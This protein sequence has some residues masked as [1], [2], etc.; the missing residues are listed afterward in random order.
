MVS[1]KPP[2][3]NEIWRL[4]LTRRKQSI[5]YNIN[6]GEI[7]MKTLD[8][9]LYYCEEPE[10]V[11]AVLLTG[12]WGCG[13][14][15][16]IDNELKEALENKAHL[17]RIS[18]FGITTIEG[19]HMAVKQEWISEYTKGKKWKGVVE[20]AQQGREIAGKLDFL[21]E[22]VRGI[23]TTDWQSF[24]EIE[25]VIEEKPV[26]L[27]FDDLERSCLDTVDVLGTINNYCENQKFH[28]IIVA[29]QDKMKISAESTAIPIEFEID[30]FENEDD[31]DPAKRAVGKIK[32]KAPKDA[33]ELSY[34][35]IKEKIIHRTIRYI[36][37]YAGIV[38]TVIDKTKY[39]DDKYK[40]FVKECE[41][42]IW[43]LFAPDRNTYNESQNSKRPHN[44]R[45]LKCAIRDFY[46]VYEILVENGFE[47]IDKWFYSFISY[48]IAYKANIAKEGRYGTLLSDK[49]VQEL[50]PAFQNQYM[51][52]TVK[53]WI[54]RGMWDVDALTYEIGVVQSKKKAE[55]PSDIVRTHRI[56]DVEE[57]VIIEGFPQ[58]VEMAY[59]GKLSL[60]EYVY[61]IWNNSWARY[62]NFELPVSVD[63]DKV[64]TG[65]ATVIKDLLDSRKEGQQL[66]SVIGADNRE[67]FTED[68]WNTYRLI[69]EFQNGN[70]LMFSNNKKLYIEGMREDAFT[71]FTAC[72]NKR[73]NMFDEEM[74]IVT[75]ETYA[76]GDNSEKNQFVGYFHDM[77]RGNI[78]SQD[79]KMKESLIGFRKLHALL[80]MQ[81]EGYAKCG[82]VFAVRHTEDFIRHLDDII[83]KMEENLKQT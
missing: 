24:I 67:Y 74:A 37:D 83:E 40:D 48:V 65:V 5:F 52:A 7:Q 53:E 58:V 11:G 82:K 56:M 44:I 43:E 81:K 54:L 68:E 21:P 6:R 1:I 9:L 3:Q 69:A 22:W 13:K 18:L 38:N 42:G 79:I 17:I 60:D 76:R 50:Y 75:A 36:P 51:L 47:D 66:H 31:T 45:S 35:E 39:Q 34:N 57:E 25:N 23:A 10:P 29:N 41:E 62:Y 8:E 12:E 71:A 15:Y 16:L 49:D 26:I 78:M 73:F 55:T 4:D 61:F 27:V 14:T 30:T 64:R 28:T 20:K 59:A 63:W 70:L 33:D 72:Q 32:Y 80:D 2:C 77:W 19:I 46:R